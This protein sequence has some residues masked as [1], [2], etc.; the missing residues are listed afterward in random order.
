MGA[1][2]V[3]AFGAAFDA[4]L[5]VDFAFAGAFGVAGAFGL[6]RA[7]GVAVALRFAVAFALGDAFGFVGAFAL[8]FAPPG[9]APVPGPR[10]DEPLPAVLRAVAPLAR[11]VPVD[12]RELLLF[13]P[14][15]AAADFAGF[16]DF[17]ALDPA[18]RV[19]LPFEEDERLVDV[20]RRRVV[21]CAMTLRAS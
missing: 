17:D 7:F 19:P 6:A 3:T 15:D 14:L 9:F 21:V 1:A 4:V 13:D 10:R 11:V 8:C 20:L 2:F 16:V 12:W 5:A 18:D